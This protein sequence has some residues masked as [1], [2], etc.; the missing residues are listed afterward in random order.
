MKPL[1]IPAL[2]IS[3]F[4]AQSAHA[5]G[6]YDL[7]CMLENGEQMTLS[8]ASDTVYISFEKPGGDSEEGGSV[9][10]LDIASGEAKQNLAVNTGVGTASF[11]LRGESDD[12]EGAIAFN[13]S[14]YDGTGD[15]Y[16]TVMNSMGQET[17]TVSCKPGTIRVSRS[18][19]LNGIN[20][21]GSQQANKPTSSQQQQVQKSTTPPFK[22]QFGSSVS[23]EGWNTKYGVIQLTITDDNVVLKSIRVNRGNCKMESV[24]NRI[25]PYKY[26]FGDVATFKYMK[27]DRILEASIVTDSGSWTFN[28]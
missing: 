17:S 18:L 3:L 27:C 24:G 23:N 28:N 8:H 20:G 1:I 15:A 11:T 10:K 2:F 19:L 22:V 9:I 25:L 16:Y 5:G 13:Y 4:A 21:V 7:Q 14:E 26:K 6:G 12:I